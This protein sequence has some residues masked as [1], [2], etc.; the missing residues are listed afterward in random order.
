MWVTF[1]PMLFFIMSIG[2]LIVWYIGGYQVIQDST[3]GAQLLP[4]R[5]GFTL[6]TFFTFLGYLGQFYGPLQFMSRVTDFLSRSLASAERVFE[7]LDTESDVQDAEKPVASASHR[8]TRGIQERHVRLRTPQAGAQGRQFHRRAG[9]D[10]RP[11][12]TERRGQEHDDQPD[13]PLL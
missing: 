10:D 9:R 5:N 1:F 2:N 4:D 12:G 8:R 6:G 11:G 7:V 3:L 13:L